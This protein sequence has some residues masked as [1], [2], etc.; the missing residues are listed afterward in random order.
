MPLRSVTYTVRKLKG[1][2]A[3][4]WFGEE[5]EGVGL[6]EFIPGT[7]RDMYTREYNP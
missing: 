6:A 4:S 5:S 2:F 7:L 1:V 3:E